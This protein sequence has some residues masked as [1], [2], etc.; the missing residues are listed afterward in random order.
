[1][2]WHPEI[3]SGKQKKVL[4][5]VGYFCLS[6]GFYLAGGTALAIRLGH[7]RSRDFD[8]F[9]PQGIPDPLHLAE[10][11]RTAGIPFITSQVERGT[12]H[13]AISGI[14]VSFF[15]YLYPLLKPYTIWSDYDCRLAGFA[16][17]ACMKLSALTQRA[18][19]KDFI[20]IYALAS[21]IMPFED[22]LKLYQK[23]Y[24]VQDMGHVLYALSYFD[25]ADRERMPAMV[26][27]VNWKAIKED[28]IG[29]IKI[30]GSFSF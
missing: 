9:T 22:M 23:K 12:L 26:W 8:W 4:K 2:S 15:E 21:R 24:S 6:Q 16:D 14:R 5:Q 20:D 1:M 27:K 18:S 25:D 3:L 19:R 17:I 28:L 7:R 13:G 30:L 29:R 10:Y 11:I